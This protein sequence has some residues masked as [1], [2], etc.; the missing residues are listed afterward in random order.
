MSVHNGFRFYLKPYAH[1]LALL[2]KVYVFADKYLITG[3]GEQ[4]QSKLLAELSKNSWECDDFLLAV[5]Q[6]Y[7]MAG[8]RTVGLR[9]F[10]SKR[11]RDRLDE[12]VNEPLFV[13]IV[14]D[15]PEFTACLGSV[16][17]GRARRRRPS[18]KGARRRNRGQF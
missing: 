6:I 14:R 16:V 7:A 11:A 15:L 8:R 13:N 1:P 18:R 12:L 4:A 3:L 9:R 17:R 5:R 2:C 10:I